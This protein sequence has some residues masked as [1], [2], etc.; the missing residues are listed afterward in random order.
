MRWIGE[1]VH[2]RIRGIDDP[3][4]EIV[5]QKHRRLR[6]PELELATEPPADF[7]LIRLVP[8]VREL[9]VEREAKTRIHE[10]SL[11]RRGNRGVGWMAKL[12]P[13]RSNELRELG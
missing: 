1:L 2:D 3:G 8:L 12:R 11:S 7:P 9:L 13:A 10:R 6:Q 4:L 5:G